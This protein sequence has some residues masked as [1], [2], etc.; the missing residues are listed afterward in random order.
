MAEAACGVALHD[1]DLGLLRIVGAAIGE[2]AWQATEVG[3]TLTTDQLTRLTC[4]NAGLRRRNS[5]VHNGF[6]VGGVR[7]EPVRE[8]L[9]ARLLHE[10][11]DLGIAELG[12]GLTLELGFTDL[13]RD[14]GRESFTDVVTGELGIFVLEQLLLE[15]VLVD[16][17]GQCG[18][19]ALFVGTTLVGVDRVGEG[20]HGLRVAGVPLHC[21][22]E[23]VA[24]AL[25]GE[26]DDRVVDRGLALV[27]VPDVVLESTGVVVDTG[28]GLTRRCLSSFFGFFGSRLGSLGHLG[29]FVVDD[30]GAL[31][32]QRDGQALVEEGHFLQ[33]TRNGLEVVAGGL[34]DLG[35]GPEN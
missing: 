13:H 23:L 5:L 27:D 22:L 11:L 8:V 15:R 21:D 18:A 25:G 26:S 3:R 28:L 30:L 14:D 24:G 31:V 17:C 33:T 29:S 10:G 7:L 16:R 20:V 6:R 32:G 1:V 35:I 12:L 2:L 4:G 34:E 19:E 9:V